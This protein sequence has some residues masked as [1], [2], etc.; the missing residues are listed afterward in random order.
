MRDTER[1]RQREKQ[2]LCREADAELDPRTLGSGTEPKADT[3][4]L[5]HPG[6]PRLESFK[7]TLYYCCK[8]YFY[9]HNKE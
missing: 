5:S 7:Q 4:P 9:S 2:A 8:T 1:Q 6:A 3:Q